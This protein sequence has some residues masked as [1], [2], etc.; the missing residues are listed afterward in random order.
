MTVRQYLIRLGLDS[1]VVL[2]ANPLRDY[3]EFAW[4]DPRLAS[5]PRA[6]GLVVCDGPPASTRGGRYGLVPIMKERLQ[7]GCVILLDDAGREQELAIAERWKNEL[8]A[9][10]RVGGSV[11]PYVELTVQRRPAGLR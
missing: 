5:M 7:P 10:L 8:G 4:Y 2:G 6:F 3:G 11:K 9:T 1:A